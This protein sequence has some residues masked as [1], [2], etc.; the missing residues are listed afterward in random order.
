M[1]YLNFSS[2]CVKACFD[3]IFGCEDVVYSFQLQP[4]GFW[5][6]QVD[7]G[8]P[9]GLLSIIENTQLPVDDEIEMETY[10][11]FKIAKIMY[12]L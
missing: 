12:V 6:E 1:D 3:W 8:Y 5:K 2:L 4:L 11:A 7:D 10:S 9:S